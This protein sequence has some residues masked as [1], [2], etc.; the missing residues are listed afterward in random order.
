MEQQVFRRNSVPKT[1]SFV[2]SPLSAFP[3]YTTE[4]NSKM[5]VQKNEPQELN[6]SVSEDYSESVKCIYEYIYIYKGFWENSF[7]ILERNYIY[8]LYIII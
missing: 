7:L 1:A 3:S 6:L 4:S 2:F 5:E 8:I